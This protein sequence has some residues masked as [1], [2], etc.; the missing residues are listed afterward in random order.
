M[1]YIEVDT[2]VRIHVQ[3]LGVG[4]RSSWSRASDWITSYGIVRSGVAELGHRVVC[5]SQ[6]GHGLSDRPLRGYDIARLA[7]DLVTTLVRLGIECTVVGHS[8]GGQVAFRTSTLAPQAVSKL[9]LV[10]SNG[11]RASRS[12]GFPFGAPPEAVLEAL[13]ADELEDRIA[14]RYKTIGRASVVSR[15]LG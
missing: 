1:T 8:F 5:V 4:P 11:V 12:D 14:A 13:L 2:G 7:A 3:D 10:G 6:R 9:V 15:I